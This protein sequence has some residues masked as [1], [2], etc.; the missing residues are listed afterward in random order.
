MTTP[1]TRRLAR[2]LAV[3]S[4]AA[5]AVTMSSGSALAGGYGHGHGH[6][7]PKPKPF[8]QIQLLSFNDFHGNLEAPGGSGGRLT[9][10]YTEVQD[11]KTGLYSASAQTVDAG[12]VEY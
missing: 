3:T 8:T 4:A 12:G 6:G 7:K 1:R 2:A 11:P 9:T 10:G 5:L